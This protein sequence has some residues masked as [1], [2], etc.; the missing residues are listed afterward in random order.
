MTKAN[1]TQKIPGFSVGGPVRK[2]N[3]FFFVNAQWLRL[4]R[5]V[6]VNRTVYTQQARQ[7]TW[8][9]SLTGRTSSPASPAPAST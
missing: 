3:T 5:T 1:F 8:R 6:T 4:D 9:Y 2:N 7:G